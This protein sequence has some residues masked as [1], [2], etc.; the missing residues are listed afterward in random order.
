M[1]QF[2]DIET[3]RRDLGVSQK[4]LAERAGMLAQDYSRLK[5]PSKQGPTVRTLMR[6]SKALDELIAEK[7][8]ADV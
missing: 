8:Q 6:L 2:K 5:K 4:D 7:E 3:V 1:R